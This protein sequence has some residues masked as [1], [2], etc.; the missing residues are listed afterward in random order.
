MALGG[1]VLEDMPDKERA[2]HD[3]ALNAMALQ[4]RHVGQYGEH[5]VGKNAGFQKGDVIVEFAGLSARQ[6]ECD[7]IA[8][9]LQNTLA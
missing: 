5:A 2:W 8:H 6:R 1:L 3:L 9:V 4:I 7:V